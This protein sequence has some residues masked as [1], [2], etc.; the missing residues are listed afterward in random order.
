VPTVIEQTA[1]LNAA[2]RDV[3]AY[4]TDPARRGEWNSSCERCTIEGD[5]P[6]AKG[7]RVHIAGRRA[8]PSWTG[9]YGRFDLNRGAALRLVEGVGMPFAS[10]IEGFQVEA[11]KG[12][13]RLTLRVEY[14]VSGMLRMIEP[15]TVRSR[16]R[17]TTVKSLRNVEQR[18]S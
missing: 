2:P 3:F 18:F 10:F 13:C 14:E 15:L 9:E 17:R 8:A 1:D 6:P 5:A 16:M 12:G 11:R 7:V 4:L